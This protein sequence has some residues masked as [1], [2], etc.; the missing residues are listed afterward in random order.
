MSSMRIVVQTQHCENYGAHDWDGKGECPQYWKFKGGN[1]YILQG[2]SVEQALGGQIWEDLS[3][4]IASK[5]EYF[6]EYIIS[7]DLVDDVDFNESNYVESWD[8][9]IYLDI[10]KSGVFRARRVQENDMMFRSEIKRKH[11]TWDQVEGDRAEYE[12]AL[13][14][15][16]GLILPY[17]DACDYIA[18]LEAA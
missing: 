1:T 15:A 7:M 18:S 14:F 3:A 12:S 6:E 8:A 5:S 13:E 10:T 11:E 16:N 2:V 17:K 9:P 4:A